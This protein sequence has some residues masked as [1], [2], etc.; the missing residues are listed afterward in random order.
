[1]DYSRYI[2]NEFSLEPFFNHHPSFRSEQGNSDIHHERRD[3]MTKWQH[4]LTP[5]RLGENKGWRVLAVHKGTRQPGPCSHYYPGHG[6][7][8]PQGN[9]VVSIIHN[10]VDQSL[11]PFQSQ[12]RIPPTTHQGTYR[13][14]FCMCLVA[15]L[16]LVTNTFS[17]KYPC[18]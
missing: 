13:L 4:P 11:S 18:R 1:M 8:P 5:R 10:T 14:L 15:L 7:S 17:A 16:L 9:T 6:L 12:P 3:L 2:N